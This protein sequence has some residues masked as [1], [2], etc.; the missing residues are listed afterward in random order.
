MAPQDVGTQP[1]LL[2]NLHVQLT[3]LMVFPW[4]WPGDTMGTRYLRS[5]DIWEDLFIMSPKS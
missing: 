4:S 5:P 1:Q 3:S 2:R